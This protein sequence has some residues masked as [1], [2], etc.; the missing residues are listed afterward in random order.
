MNWRIKGLVQ[1]TLSLLPAGARIN[2]LLQRTIGGLSNFEANVEMKIT[3][4]W[5]VLMSH[6]TELGVNPR[7]L[8]YVEVGTGWYPTLPL[9]YSLAGAESCTTFDVSRHMSGE[10]TLRLI[11]V[12]GNKLPAIAEASGR[13]FK[14][15]FTDYSR[16]ARCTAIPELLRS[17]RVQYFA[18]ADAAH[19]GLP[20]GSID[21]VY[22]NSVLEHLPLDTLRAI[23][24]ESLRILKPSGLCIH[25][26]NCGDHYAYFDRK[27]TAINYLQ[28]SSK[29]WRL[30]N[31]SL[32]FQNRLRPQDFLEIAENEGFCIILAKFKSKPELLRAISEM[33]IAPE[34]SRYPPDQLACTSIDF[35]GRPKL[36]GV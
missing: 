29:R 13:T 28:Y 9:C 3:A 16:L 2:D 10:L 4:D 12:L 19:T 20:S 17:A 22:S 26:A 14:E 21:V 31:N 33:K 6:M 30:W 5:K 11:K 24:R 23:M 25:S 1:G 27:I 34:F 35:V 36:T 32:L 8:K 18:P 7:G 15:V